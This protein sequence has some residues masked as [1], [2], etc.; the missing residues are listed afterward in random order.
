MV[1]Q[2]KTPV[3]SKVSAQTA[4]EHIEELDREY[5]EVT[6]SLLLEDSRPETAVLHPLYEW[7]DEKAAEK[8]RL[9][10]SKMIIG[11]LVVV[12][13][14]EQSEIPKVPVRAFVSVND[15]NEKASYRPIVSVLADEASREQ[16]LANAL[17]ELRMFK[18]KYEAILDVAETLR[19]FANKIAPT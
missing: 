3:F 11:N 8:Y 17:T 5:G 16:I 10:Q 9:H 13:I 18:S 7:N 4:G 1:Y 6:P 2:W 12:R 14:D 15:R 19:D